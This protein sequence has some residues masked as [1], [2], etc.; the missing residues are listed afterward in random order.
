MRLRRVFTALIGALITVAATAQ[1]PDNDKI[2]AAI[3]D[4]NSPF[5]YP[6]LMM[7]YQAGEQLTD[8][9]YHYLY[10]GYAYQAAYRPLNDN[11]GMTKV[12]NIMAR[13]A[14]DTPSVTDI[15]QLIAAG[16]E[17]MEY[18]PFS[19][20]LLNIMAYA[21]G[22]AGDKVREKIYS[23]HLQA[24][25][26]I[27]AASGTGLK[28]KEAMHIIFFSHGVDFIAAK[29]WNQL[30]G[31]IISREVEFI[32]FEA[33]K[34]KVKGYYFDYSRVYWNKPDN[35]TFERERTWQFNNLKPRQYK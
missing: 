9:Q 27:I 19:P 4:S 8:E 34:D 14:I 22:T 11:P 7:K 26:R 16:T 31:K 20:K 29:G 25:L 18:D 23:D 30:K 5:Y 33:P 32:P 6:N 15:D 21:Y 3:N 1:T 2:F 13:I 24:V 35:Y 12:Q 28:E 10:Y 17:A